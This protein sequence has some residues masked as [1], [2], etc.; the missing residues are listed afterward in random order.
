[1]RLTTQALAAALVLLPGG[2]AAL[3]QSYPTK[4]IRLIVPFV[5]G[6]GLDFI[7]R[8]ISPKLSD[9]LGQTIVVDN[10]PGASGSIGLELA[11]RAPADGYTLGIFSASHVIHS[12]LYKTSYDLFRDFAP[13][14]QTSA[15]PYVFAVYPALPV[16]SVSEFIAYARANPGKLNYASSG[17]GTLQH[18]VTELFAVTV[19]VKLVHV[20][21]KGVA[22]AYPDLLSGRVHM[23]AASITALAPLIRSKSVRALGVTSVQRMALL[24]EVPTMIEAGIPGF[25]VTQWH[26]TLAPAGTPR[27]VV[28]RLHREIVKALQEP[29]VAARLANDGTDIVGSSPREFAAYLKAEQQRWAKVITQAGIRAE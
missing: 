12:T 9:S 24:P 4:P 20:P 22:A 13:V 6:G 5:P 15:A 8:L 18:L 28:E 1:M 17:H 26:G 23:I 16:T 11:A 29:E 27:P 21:Y 3:A 2:G 7:A 25:T 14:T 19:G 10:R